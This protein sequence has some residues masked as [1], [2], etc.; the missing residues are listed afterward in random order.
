MLISDV[1]N[2]DEITALIITELKDLGVKY[3]KEK[4]SKPAQVKFR[5]FYQFAFL[6][7]FVHVFAGKMWQEK[8][9]QDSFAPFGFDRCYFSKRRSCPNSTICCRSLS[10]DSRE[11][12]SRRYFSKSRFVLEAEGN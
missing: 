6:K 10:K 4:K 1:Q 9:I 5:P 7:G 3:R 11:C 12:S 8:D 2:K